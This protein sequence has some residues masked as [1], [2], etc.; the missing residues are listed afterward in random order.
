MQGDK[1]RRAVG[2]IHVRFGGQALVRASRVPA[3]LPWPSG[4]QVADRL[5]GIGGLPRGRISV[6][7]GTPASGRLSLGLAALARA[8]REFAR[9]VESGPKNKTSHWRKNLSKRFKLD[10]TP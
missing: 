7:R 8:T 9:P 6:L 1:L 5:S 2:A 3:A 10:T 4:L